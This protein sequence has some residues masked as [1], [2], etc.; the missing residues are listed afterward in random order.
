MNI[1]MIGADPELFIRN[2]ITKEFIPSVGMLGGT[3]EDPFFYDDGFAVQEDNVTAEYNIPPATTAD[4]WVRYHKKA[5][6]KLKELVGNENELVAKASAPFDSMWFDMYPELMESGCGQDMNVYSF[7][8]SAP[9][10]SFDNR[11]RYAGGHVH[12]SCDY[13]WDD[14]LNLIKWLD[15]LIAVP[16]TKMETDGARRLLYGQAGVF[17]PKEYGIEYRTPSSAWTR[18]EK[19]QRYVF[20]ATQ[21]AC[22]I[23]DT[24]KDLVLVPNDL[25]EDAINKRNM[26]SIRIIMNNYKDLYKE[27]VEHARNS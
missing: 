12:V 11:T 3:K 15:V 22:E 16:F 20:A 19:W 5:W 24:K 17:R 23:I 1:H 10:G 7:T 13:D 9:D 26:E 18:Y 25:I 6:A 8:P 14:Q 4:D 2:L 27:V 21:K